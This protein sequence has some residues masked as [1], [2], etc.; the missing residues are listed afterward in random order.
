MCPTPR[1]SGRAASPRPNTQGWYAAT[2]IF[3]YGGVKMDLQQ[4]K[5]MVAFRST[6]VSL[7]SYGRQRHVYCRALFSVSVIRHRLIYRAAIECRKG[8]QKQRRH[9][10]Y[11]SLG[12]RT[13]LTKIL[14]LALES[15][16]ETT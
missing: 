3:G 14:W 8:L 6:E 13:Q 2:A 1:G 5:P 7:P 4:P 16:M 11:P 9:G 15:A 12:Y 10:R